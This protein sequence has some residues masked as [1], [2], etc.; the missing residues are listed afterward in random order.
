MQRHLQRFAEDGNQIRY[1]SLSLK[2]RQGRLRPE[3]PRL[4]EYRQR[5]GEEAVEAGD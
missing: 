3:V 5:N 2:K 4:Q 1:L